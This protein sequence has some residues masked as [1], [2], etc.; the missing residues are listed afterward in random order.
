MVS[1][2]RNLPE[3]SHCA[4]LHAVE[5]LALVLL[6]SC[7]IA[8]RKLAVSILREVRSLFT[9][10]GQSEVRGTRGRGGI[11][12][13]ANMVTGLKGRCPACFWPAK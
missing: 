5:G 4:V 8:T 7:H 11:A 3:R 10:I 12:G 13:G 6:C 9:A 2:Q 1:L